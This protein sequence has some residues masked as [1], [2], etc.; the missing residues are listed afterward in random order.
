MARRSDDPKKNE[1]MPMSRQ[2]TQLIPNT[3]SNDGST[4]QAYNSFMIRNKW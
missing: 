4:E 1:H 2:K 3:K